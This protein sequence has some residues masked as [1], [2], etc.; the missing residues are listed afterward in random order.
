MRFDLLSAVPSIF[1][2]W[3]ET[4]ILARGQ[5]AGAIDIRVHDLR[6]WAHDRHRTVDDYPYGGGAGMLLKP[7]PLWEAIDS[8][9]AEVDD[10]P[11]VILMTPQGEPFRQALAAELAT[12]DRLILVCGRYE[13]VDERVRQH[14]VDRC[15]S[16]GDFVVTGGELPAMMV[17]DAV[18]RLVPGVLGA[19]ESAEDESFGEGLLEYPQ[20]T[21]PAS[22]RGYEVPEEL[23]GGHHERVRLWRRMESLRRTLD[24]RPDL[25]AGRALS[26]EERRL[27]A[28]LLASEQKG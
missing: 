9:R 4:S 11:Q 14:A 15:L 7:A 18:A 6:D 22:Y 25:L 27:L 16:V 21:R 5:V 8:L 10:S 2:S 12:A 19:A 1:E 23:L 24:Q 20:Y 13:G 26:I 17:V 3:R 28:R